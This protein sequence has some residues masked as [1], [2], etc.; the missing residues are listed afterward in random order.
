MLRWLVVLAFSVALFLPK[1]ARACATCAAG[2]PTLD[3]SGSEKAFEARKRIALD[4]RATKAR[5]A[6]VAIAEERLEL[7]AD[8]ATSSSFLVS[9]S[10]PAIHRSITTFDGARSNELVLGDAELRASAT[11]ADTGI[12]N[13]RRKVLVFGGSKFPTAPLQTDAK[14]RDLP[15]AL[16]PGCGAIDPMLG[17]ALVLTHAPFTLVGSTL[18]YLPF[19]VREGPH[20]GDSWRSSLTLQIQPPRSIVATRFGVSTRL[21]QAGLRSEGVVDPDSGGF[22][23]SISGEVLVSPVRDL[24]LGAGVFA[25][26]VQMLRGDQ[27]EGAIALAS[28]ALDF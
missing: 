13:V 24:V 4:A 3:A 9:A 23:A 6:D 22:V 21:D 11:I 8:L 12:T 28:V 15:V 2:D 14:G 19:S 7:R 26:A 16:Q 17:A 25:P 18:F 20:A 10:L 27:H 5:A 1:T